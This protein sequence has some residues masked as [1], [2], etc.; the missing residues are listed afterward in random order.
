MLHLYRQS[1]LLRCA[2]SVLSMVV[3][4]SSMDS[5]ITS[6]MIYTVS[7][8]EDSRAL[9]RGPS[10]TCVVSMI[11]RTDEIEE[12]LELRRD[13]FIFRHACKNEMRTVQQRKTQK[14]VDEA[15]PESGWPM[16]YCL[17]ISGD[18]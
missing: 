13:S 16:F 5:Q 7:K 2:H 8:I 11:Q 18:V 3:K 4:N 17:S 15:T 9:L 6:H 14:E 1:R 10:Y 12:V